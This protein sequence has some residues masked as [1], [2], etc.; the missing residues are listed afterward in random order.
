MS[1]PVCKKRFCFINRANILR[2]SGQFEEAVEVYSQV[3]QLQPDSAETYNNLGISLYKLNQFQ[4]A[5]QAYYD[6]IELNSECAEAY[7]NFGTL[8]QK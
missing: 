5:A 4:S 2:E 6:A 1:V 8:L 3:I 7:Y